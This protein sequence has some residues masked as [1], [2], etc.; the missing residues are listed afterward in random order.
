MKWHWTDS[1]GKE[2]PHLN[3]VIGDLALDRGS[4][5]LR[6]LDLKKLNLQEVPEIRY[7]NLRRGWRSICRTIGYVC[8]DKHATDFSRWEHHGKRSLF[9]LGVLGPRLRKDWRRR[10]QPVTMRPS[11]FCLASAAS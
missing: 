6:R 11:E 1:Q 3:I 5:E 10:I 7:A 8:Q 4:G 2:F 9:R